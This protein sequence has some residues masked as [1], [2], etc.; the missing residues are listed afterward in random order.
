MTI[1]L[2]VILG[3]IALIHALWGLHVWVPFRDEERLARAFVGAKGVTRMPGTIPCFLVAAGLAMIIAALWMPQILL[4]RI[5]LWVAFGVFAIR[6]ALGYT[7]FWRQM[8]PEQPFATYDRKYYAPLC[9]L[10]AA[11]LLATLLG[12]L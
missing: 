8:T 7:K 3:T 11:G 12:G 10:L 2:T 1:L 9:L 6:G 5:V 4:A